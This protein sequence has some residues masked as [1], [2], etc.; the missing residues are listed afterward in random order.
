MIMR[1][2]FHRIHIH[3]N[4]TNMYPS[5]LSSY[6]IKLKTK[7]SSHILIHLQCNTIYC[8]RDEYHFVI[9]NTL[10]TYAVTNNNRG[11]LIS[12]ENSDET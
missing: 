4:K 2:N 7:Y 8:Y 11:T 3:P 1:N 5:T 6:N 12:Q 9:P 10:D